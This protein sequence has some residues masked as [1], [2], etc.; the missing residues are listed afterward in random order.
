MMVDDTYHLPGCPFLHGKECD[1]NKQDVEKSLRRPTLRWRQGTRLHLSVGLLK[2]ILTSTTPTSTTTSEMSPL[3][4]GKQ[5][6][7]IRDSPPEDP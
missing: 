4:E 7:L 2:G 6:V 1:C 5:Q 3:P